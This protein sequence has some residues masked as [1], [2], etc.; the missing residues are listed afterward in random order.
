MVVYPGLP[1]NA[2][3]DCNFNNFL[4]FDPYTFESWMRI[5]K[6]VPHSILWLLRRPAESEKN[7]IRTDNIFRYGFK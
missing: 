6:N 4:E 3:V 5:L 2:I 1:E 7:T